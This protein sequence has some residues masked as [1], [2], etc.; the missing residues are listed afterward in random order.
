MELGFKLFE[1]EM[2]KLSIIIPVYNVEDYITECVESVLN[3]TFCDIEI[4]L[5]DDGSTDR[6]GLI[7]DNFATEDKRIKVIHKKNGGLSSARNCGI[8]EAQGDYLTFI[9]GDDIIVG[10]ETIGNLMSCLEANNDIDIIQYDVIHKYLSQMAHK[11]SYPFTTYKNKESILEAYMKQNIHVSCCDKIFKK[12]IFKDI[13]FPLG[14]ISEDIAI[15]PQIVENTC[16]LMTSEIGYYGYRYREGSISNDVLPY[17]KICS[18]LE[19]YHKYLSYAMKYSKLMP[20][21]IQMHADCVWGYS[22]IIRCR[23]P[24]HVNIFCNQVKI[25]KV[26]L[27][28]WILFI[29]HYSLTSII[30]TFIVCVLGVKWAFS[31]QRL[32]SRNR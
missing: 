8:E 12:K 3:Q 6:S 16:N 29:N 2:A 1:R 5:V 14:Q 24:D 7:C 27:Y 18:I 32:L 20:L 23:Y 17:K 31:F 9:D 26:P 4:I 10:K 19:S 11:R 22:S 13:R 25:I 15:I 28:R 30:R 21:A